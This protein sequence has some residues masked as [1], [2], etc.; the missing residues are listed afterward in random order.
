MKYGIHELFTFL[1]RLPKKFPEFAPGLKLSHIYLYT[2]L[3]VPI[4]P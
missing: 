2:D 3:S 4:L 1:Q